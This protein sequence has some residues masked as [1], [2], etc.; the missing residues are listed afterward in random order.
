M[1]TCLTKAQS[2]LRSKYF[3]NLWAE[4]SLKVHDKHNFKIAKAGIYVSN[5]M[6]HEVGDWVIQGESGSRCNLYNWRFVLSLTSCNN[7]SQVVLVVRNLPANAGDTRDVGLIPGLG[8]FPGVEHGTS[9]QY[10]CLESPMDRG[11][12]QATEICKES[13]TTKHTHNSNSNEVIVEIQDWII[14]QWQWLIGADL[15]GM[16]Y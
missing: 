14:S 12:W 2:F 4:Q 3:E 7:N 8:R 1:N 10:S 6:W 9:L 5:W 11:A 13:D 15:V 16:E